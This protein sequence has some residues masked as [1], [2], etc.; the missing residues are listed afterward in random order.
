MI[1]IVGASGYIGNNLF[2][3]FKEKGQEIMGT[4]CRHQKAG[5]TYFD[6]ETSKIADLILKPSEVSH[7]IVTASINVITDETKKN[8]EK[9]HFINAVKTKELIRFCFENNIIPIYFSTDNIFDGIKG[10]YKEDDATNPI[11]CYGR[12]KDE[13]EKYLRSS[14][15]LFVIVRLGRVFGIEK[16][17][18]TI[19]TSTLETVMANKK[20][21]W[22]KDQYF[23]PLYIEDLFQFINMIIT[24]KQEGIFHLASLPKTTRYEIA[25][26]IKSYFN[27]HGKIMPCTVDSLDFL[28]KRPKLVDLNTDKYHKMIGDQEKKIEYFLQLIKERH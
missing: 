4:Y 8:W 12:I 1:V 9:S 6:L 20:Q 15:K 17:D 28:D 19:L 2:R 23:T 11:N 25:T 14:G 27:L 10:N 24:Q 22:I 18:G 21:H 7:I 13:V 3:R 16:G 5:L 26:A